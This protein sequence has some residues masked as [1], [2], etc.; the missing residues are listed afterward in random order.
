M[1]WLLGT[2]TE[3]AQC[4]S[5]GTGI[6]TPLY[7][8]GLVPLL[9]T[10]SLQ[11][12]RFTG[13][14]DPKTPVPTS[15]SPAGPGEPAWGQRA[16]TQEQ[17]QHLTSSSHQGAR[18]SYHCPN[19]DVVVGVLLALPVALYSSSQ[20]AKRYPRGKQQVGGV[21]SRECCFS[22]AAPPCC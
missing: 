12:C 16:G 17:K 4:P 9:R 1:A 10:M 11:V 22:S 6:F 19:P 15:V 18:A 20:G 21:E 3:G 7:S 5:Q 14:T 13:P 8:E 2:V